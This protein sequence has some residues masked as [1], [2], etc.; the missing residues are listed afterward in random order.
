M[1]SSSIWFIK[2]KKIDRKAADFRPL[3][4]KIITKE[5]A[6]HY[7]DNKVIKRKSFLKIFNVK[8]FS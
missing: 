7:R 5:N 6:L 1:S 4:K 2:I 8:T 3:V